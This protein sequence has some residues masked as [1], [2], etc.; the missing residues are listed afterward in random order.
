MTNR[1]IAAGLVLSERTVDTHVANILSKLNLK[2]RSQVAAWAVER[3][4]VSATS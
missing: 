1:E 3:G 4:I 2:S